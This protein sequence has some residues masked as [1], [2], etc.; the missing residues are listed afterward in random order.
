MARTYANINK[1]TLGFICS[2]IGVTAVFLSQ[3]TRCTEEKIAAWLDASN[4][5]FPTLKQAKLLA[6]ALKIPFADLYMNKETY[7]LNSCL[8]YATCEHCHILSL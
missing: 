8:R 3:R 4:D 5:T 7:Q 2:Q 1:E 6:K